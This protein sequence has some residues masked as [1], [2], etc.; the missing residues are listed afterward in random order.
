MIIPLRYKI[1]VKG[2]ECLDPKKG[3][4]NTSILFLANHSSHIDG[5]IL[6][7]TLLK[8]KLS[9]T[10]WALDLTFKLPYLRWAARHKDTVK[11][12]KVPNINETRSEKHSSRLHKLVTRTADGLNK[13]ENFLIFPTGR[14]KKTPIEKI[15]GKSAIPLILRQC[16]DVTYHPCAGDRPVG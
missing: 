4:I 9:L 8:Q 6:G 16:P 13:G 12:V 7:I 2:A 3:G 11:V 1:E 5:T 14:V 10:I 15:D